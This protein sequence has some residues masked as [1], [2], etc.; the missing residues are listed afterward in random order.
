MAKLNF[1]HH[2]YILQCYII[3][4]KSLQYAAFGA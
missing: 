1:Q 2:Y 3:L 4:Q